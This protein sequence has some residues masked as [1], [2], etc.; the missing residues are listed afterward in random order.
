MFRRGTL[1]LLFQKLCQ[2]LFFENGFIY[3]VFDK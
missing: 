2:N 1:I 3:F